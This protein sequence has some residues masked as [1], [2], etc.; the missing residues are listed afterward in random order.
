MSAQPAEL[1]QFREDADYYGEHYEDLLARYPNQWVAIYRQQL[2]GAA[3]VLDDLL[4]ELER[5]GVPA[6]AALVK[7]MVTGDPVFIL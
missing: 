5:R 6:E 1:A 2:V 7:Y 3:P 4:T